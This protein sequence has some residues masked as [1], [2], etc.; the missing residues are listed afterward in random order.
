MGKLSDVQIRA[1]MRAGE[2]FEGRADGGGLVLRYRGG[3]ALPSWRFRYSIGGE[4]RVM[5]LGNYGELSLAD[6]RKTAKELR[7]RVLLGNDV[8]GEKSERVKTAKAKIEA[9][10]SAKTVA[11]LADEYF[12]RNILGRWKHPNIVRSRIE[13]DIKPAIGTL[14][15]EDVKPR[16][17]DDMLKAVVKRGAPTTANDVLRWVRRMFDYAIKR[18]MIELNPAAAFDL[19]DA[20]GKEIA[21]ERALSRDELVT[22]FEAMREAKG[23]SVEN[24]LA[25]KLLLALAVRKMELIGARW[26]EFDLDA[27]TWHL[28]GERTKTGAPVDIP[29]APVVVDWLRELQRLAD[30]SEWVFPARKMQTRMV[31]HICESTI[32]VALG[33]VKHGLPHFTAHDFRRTARTHLAALG[34][35]PHVAERCLNHKLKGV[36][37]IYNRHDYFEE[38]KAAL[39]TWAALLVEIE[40]G[41][42]G[43]VVPIKGRKRA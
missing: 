4:P 38:R 12:E 39:A 22:F 30:G 36:E 14:A 18:H 28:P 32:G 9:A 15:L 24:A 23:F 42:V 17:I 35:E 34:V 31:P 20:G 11:D 43:K 19:S 8:A 33:K 37:G 13:K 1:W 40:A 10:R 7:A 25:V 3:D 16:H 29:L 2:R 26:E 27:A 41:N 6:A 5:H 21:R